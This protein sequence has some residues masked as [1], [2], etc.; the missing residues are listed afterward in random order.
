M[1]KITRSGL[2][3]DEFAQLVLVTQGLAGYTL[4]ARK[5][6]LFRLFLDT[7]MVNPTAVL[8][9]ITVRLG[10]LSITRNILIPSGSLLVE[11]T[12]PYGPNVG[13]VFTGDMFPFPGTYKVSFAV[14]GSGTFSP[15]FRLTELAF[16]PPG[17][18]RLLIHN[19]VGTAPW[20]TSIQPD[21]GWLIQMF[22]ALERFSAMA[23]VRDGI[24]F[25]LTHQ[26]AGICFMFGE[27][28]DPWNCPSGLCTQQEKIDNLLKE[29]K[30]INSTGTSEHVDAT[31]G[32]RPRDTT[33]FPPPSGESTGGKAFPSL[34]LTSFVGGNEGGRVKTGSVMAQEVGHIFG[35]VPP[36]SPHSDGGGHSKNRAVI[37]P[38]AFDFLRLKP[39]GAVGGDYIGDVMGVGW[40][41]GDDMVLFNAFD[42]EHFRQEL[43]QLPFKSTLATADGRPTKREQNALLNELDEIFADLPELKVADLKK[44]LPTKKGVRWHWTHRGF[45]PVR[46]GDNIKAR[47]GLSPS[48]EG[49]RNWLEQLGVAD[50]YTPIDQR[51]LHFVINP[52]TGSSVAEDNFEVSEKSADRF[53]GPVKFGDYHRLFMPEG[54]AA[55]TDRR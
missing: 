41:Q 31:L 46:S 42:W 40:H 7:A 11:T 39:Y 48:A 45:E 33:M 34:A 26:D 14:Q 18:V 1:D 38:Y 36:A 55:G 27:N 4:V 50:V 47:S 19:L 35:L 25:G 10:P 12:S 15:Q 21:F 6:I 32:W 17:R 37:D 13:V 53:P 20:G 24:K 49:I 16:L 43:G 52:N 5:K 23:P 8:A 2:H 54:S 30:A 3:S 9:T 44:A 29:T 22:Q 28:I 51:S